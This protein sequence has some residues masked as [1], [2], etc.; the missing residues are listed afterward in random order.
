MKNMIYALTFLHLIYA[1]K[2]NQSQR[3]L[4]NSEITHSNAVSR[5]LSIPKTLSYQG[6]LTKNDGRPV[7]DGTYQITFRFYAIPEGGDFI[8]EE[9][10]EI[11]I[12]DGII[13]ATLGLT[14][15][16]D[17]SSEGV[18]L[19]II[20]GEISLLPRQAI[21]SVLYSMVS[22]T[23][24]Y[25][26]GGNYL[27]L[28]NL[29]NLS[30]FAAKDTLSNFPLTSN[31][32]SVAF[33]GSYHSLNDLPDLSGFSQSDTLTYYVMSDSL[34]QYTLTTE[35]GT[36]A[37]SN[38]YN[39]LINQPNLS[40]YVNIDTLGNFAH[41]DTLSD[42]LLEDSVG[43]I[44]SQ[45]AENVEITG[46]SISG[47][48]SLSITDGGTGA[49]DN[50]TARQ[51]LGLEIN[52]DVQA[53]DADVADLADGELSAGKVQY[54]QNVTSDIQIQL[55]ALTDGPVYNL[56]DLG[57]TADSLELNFVDG[58]TSNIQDQLNAKQDL[59]DNLTE[60]LGLSHSDGNVIVSDG[61]SWTAESGST[62]RTSLGLG[63]IATQAAD[64]VSITGGSLTGVTD[65]A[66]SD[67][68]TGASDITTARSNLGLEIGVDVQA[69]DSDLA[70]LADGT[71]SASK[72][73]HNEYFITSA[74]ISGKVWTSDGDGAGAWTASSA[75]TVTVS[76]NESTN[77][78]NAI[79]FTSGGDVDGG[80]LGLESDGD[81]TYNPSTGTIAATNFSGNLTG[82]L[83]T[84]AQSNVTSLGTLT[85]L[86]VDNVITNGTTIG[87]TDDTDLMTLANGSVTFTGS[88]VIG[89]ADVN[90]GAIDGVAIGS[91][92]AS[93]GAFTTVSASG[94]TDLNS[95]LNTSGNVSL[96][97]S[98][99]EL[100]FY[101]GSNYV[102]FEAPSL[103]ADQ[104]WVLPTADGSAN[105]VLKTDG[106]GALGWADGGATSVNGLSD[107][108]SGG[109]NFSNSMILGHQTTGTLNSAE[110][111]VGVG[112]GS[113]QAITEGDE[114]VGVGYN[115][116]YNNT[117]GSRNSAL[118]NEAMYS[119]TTG[120]YNAGLGYRSLYA[121]TTGSFNTAVGNSTLG[122]NTTGREN[123]GLGHKALLSNTTG[124]NNV[125]V[126]RRTLYTTTTSHYNSAVGAYALEDAN[127]TSNTN[128][129]NVAFGYNAGNTGTNDI[130]TG[131]KN[132]LLG[133]ST[134]ASAAAGTNQTVIGY[135]ASGKGDNTVTIGNG[136]ITLWSP[137]DDN[138][139]DLG[140]SSVEF[141]DLYIDGTANLDAVDIDG[142][143]IDGAAIGANSAST[144]A[145]TT[146]TASTSVDVT[147][148][149]GLILENDETITNSTDG[150]VVIN[151]TVSG[152]T[153]SA[154]GVFTSN[155]DQDVTL[156]TGNST[157]GSITITDGAN[158]NITVA[159]NGT[160]KADFNDSPLTGYGADVQTESGT[161]KT[162]AAADNGTIIVCSSNSAVTITVP[163]SLPTG[164]NCMIIQSGSGQVSLSASS[165]TLNNRN[166]TKTAGQHAIMTVVH[167][168]SNA[169][170][171]SGDTSS[172]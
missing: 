48:A 10:H 3:A 55:D 18:Y 44:A 115:T 113:L 159:P 26:Q 114:L 116:F 39:D 37:L 141:K 165:T 169:F 95:T 108:K 1:Q 30:V 94:A 121:N 14:N 59:N 100:R 156:Q 53:Y 137:S 83:Q 152:G 28:E 67:G 117:T 22:D 62:A 65:I 16:V 35:L 50:T 158:G 102:G 20:V 129:Y 85:T 133:A 107:A 74:G 31:L 88:T 56:A 119:N 41:N 25:S 13:S 139:V 128:G 92:S 15:P 87:H 77:E 19:E 33:T 27:D 166:G 76:D 80:T 101:E 155:G 61:S 157:T 151:G 79:V 149:A 52:V 163:A 23:A 12:D 99:N 122:S 124:E 97:G 103:S 111:N 38:D 96:D 69:Y 145:F 148:S 66:V 112:Y 134:A 47:I 120:S 34:S 146:I 132:T 7:D 118:G 4:A 150:T 123:S 104:I 106:S 110:Y 171:V 70:D 162:L 63:S 153:G 140:S 135:G 160:G 81:A 5:N 54:L 147:G 36:V 11:E 75:T 6:L 72:V 40:Q 98:A 73:E 51:N 109:S 136:D 17:F 82:T 49:S 64:A 71:L 45:D 21:T 138:E 164:F 172:S 29:P 126:G 131:N 167:L 144:G 60:I 125:A 154:A 84:A 42:F 91:N 43:S 8:W 57:I 68:G 105:Q 78:S 86:T 142:G 161:S 130:T 90:G 143:A 46:G 58:V 9:I 24:N 89:T 170:V 32:D 168:G 93:T 127:R 2:H